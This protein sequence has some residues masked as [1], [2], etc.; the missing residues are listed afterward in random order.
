M[1][2]VNKI[3]GS[4]SFSASVLSDRWGSEQ[5]RTEASSVNLDMTLWFLLIMV[6]QAERV[7][8]LLVHLFLSKLLN[9]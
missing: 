5:E 2:A 6:S 7:P 4:E 8:T 1:S 3:S 9:P